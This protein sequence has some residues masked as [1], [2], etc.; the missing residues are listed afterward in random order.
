[1]TSRVIQ[2]GLGLCVL[3]ASTPVFAAQRTFVS[4]NGVN[5]PTCSLAAPCRDFATAITATS[6]EGEVIVLDSGG[7]GPVT[8]TQ[9]VSIIAPPGVFAG[10][11]VFAGDGVT[12]AAGPSDSV[13]LRGLSINGQGGSVG[14][15]VASGHDIHIERCVVA[16]LTQYGIRTEGGLAIHISD[17]VVRSNTSNG[18]LVFGGNPEVFVSDSRF[19][20]NGG[21]G[22]VQQY[23]SLALDRV[24]S[25]NNAI[26][27]LAISPNTT[28][29]VVR[30]TIRDSQFAGSVNALTVSTD[31]AGEAAEVTIERSALVR[32][33]GTGVSALTTG[34]GTVA[35]AITRS[36]AS[37]NAISGV[38]A[39]GSGVTML[40]DGSTLSRN[41][42]GMT[43]VNSAALY[44]YGNNALGGNGVPTSGTILPLTL[45]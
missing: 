22:I 41:G 36:V 16:S 10:I 12:V 44:T 35:L 20:D 2:I 37:E 14:I 15:R 26:N 28:A 38:Y 18:L 24:R 29:H 8:I 40:V 25:E 31:T 21:N 9:S 11:S 19:V 43:Q 45:Q 30:T 23:G 27:G 7:Y 32:S 4:T 3:V 6:P 17:T 1:M 5:N 34:A 39:D 13:V 42:V 33:T